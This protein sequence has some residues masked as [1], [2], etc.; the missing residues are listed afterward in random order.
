MGKFSP[1]VILS[2][3]NCRNFRKLLLF[4]SEIVSNWKTYNL[5]H[6]KSTSKCTVEC[7]TETAGKEFSGT[8]IQVKK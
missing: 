1:E 2:N 4:E 8:L 5:I 3:F 7:S 6:F